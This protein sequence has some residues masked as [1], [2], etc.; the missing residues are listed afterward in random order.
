M[1]E[2]ENLLDT[3]IR[4]KIS[5]DIIFNCKTIKKSSIQHICLQYLYDEDFKSNIFKK[6]Y[7][8]IAI[9]IKEK[10]YEDYY[11]IIL[12]ITK[13]ENNSESRE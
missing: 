7:N 11:L 5:E 13:N 10:I 4:D 9:H 6:E 12:A 2:L 3:N 8:S 1:K